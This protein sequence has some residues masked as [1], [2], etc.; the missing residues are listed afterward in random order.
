[1]VLES[2]FFNNRR[3]ISPAGI[4]QLFTVHQY[5]HRDTVSFLQTNDKTRA[6]TRKKRLILI[7]FSLYFILDIKGTSLLCYPDRE[8]CMPFSLSSHFH[9]LH[10]LNKLFIFLKYCTSFNFYPFCLLYRK[11]GPAPH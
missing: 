3:P 11:E 5:Q 7:N 1:M 8:R 6:S 2:P 9:F 10:Y 4:L